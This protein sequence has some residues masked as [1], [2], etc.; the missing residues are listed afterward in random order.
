MNDRA[1]KERKHARKCSRKRPADVNR[2][3]KSIVEDA[4]SDEP[5]NPVRGRAGGKK[6]GKARAEKLTSEQ[7]T[8]IARKG[9]QARWAQEE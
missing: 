4:V 1:E 8:A 7:R 5:D 9:A 6:G 3:A 2:L